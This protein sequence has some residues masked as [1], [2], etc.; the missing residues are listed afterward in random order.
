[1]DSLTQLAKSALLGNIETPALPGKAGDL[2]LPSD[3]DGM[4]MAA[5]ILSLYRE[6]GFQPAATDSPLPA[7][8]PEESL[9]LP[10][11]QVANVVHGMLDSEF[12]ALIRY[13][14]QHLR[15]HTWRVP[16][17]ELP[18]L[19][20]LGLKHPELQIPIG[21]VA[22][23]RG[24]WLAAHNPE[25]RYLGTGAAQLDETQWEEGTS[26]ERATYLRGLR[27]ADPDQARAKLAAVFAAE[28]AKNRGMLLGVLEEGLSMRDEVFLHDILGDRSK[29]VAK[30]AAGLLSRLPQ[31]RL[32]QQAQTLLAASLTWKGMLK[33]YWEFEPPRSFSAELK[34]LAIQENTHYGKDIGQRAGWLLQL[35]ALAPLEWWT[36]TLGESPA[37]LYAQAKKSEWKA[38]LRLGWEQAV[39]GQRNAV[40][41]K[42]LIRAGHLRGAALSVLD[43]A[44]L[45]EVTLDL[46]QKEPKHLSAHLRQL[47]DTTLKHQRH[48]SETASRECLRALQRH[49]LKSPHAHYDYELRKAIPAL[50][51]ALHPAVLAEALDGWPRDAAHWEYF[52]GVFTEYSR[53]V[54]L[55]IAL[56][57]L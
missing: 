31:S 8:C 46:M 30:T 53:F 50:A 45:E 33:K 24:R 48:W 29:E 5:G 22:G 51:C 7:A 10:P 26:A 40:W 41:A 17:S 16:A 23:E 2:S 12:P 21:T 34:A 49:I 20:E 11:A 28:T 56:E 35:V 4:L 27:A 43:P 15:D 9:A 13:G 3:A 18:R 42:D 19:L 54:R 32:A 37:A 1:M 55:R 39:T 57:Q 52:G 25:W 36:E 44:D 47:L 6:A 38:A 14:L